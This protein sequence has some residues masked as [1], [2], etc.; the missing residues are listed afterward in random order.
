MVTLSNCCVHV[1]GMTVT[2]L[3]R[4]RAER[5]ENHGSI[6]GVCVCGGWGGEGGG[7]DDLFLAA[8]PCLLGLFSRIKTAEA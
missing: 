8:P 7:G 4:L 2:V 5:P 3:T 6:P 1:L